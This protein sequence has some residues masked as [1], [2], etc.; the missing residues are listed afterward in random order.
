LVGILNSDGALN[1][2][3]FRASET[4]FQLLTQVS[5]RAGRGALE[6]EVYIQTTLPENQTIQFAAQQDYEAFY[7]TEI[8]VRKLFDYPPFN[9]LI[10]ITFSGENAKDTLQW[11]ENFRNYLLKLLPNTFQLQPVL[12]SGY[13]KIKDNYRFQLIIKGNQI[14]LFNKVLEQSKKDCPLPRAIKMIVD[15]NPSSTFF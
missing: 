11:S 13:S 2:P 8:A 12:P 5:G 15:V 7:K 1:I 10:K 4:V 9:Q 14:Y 3:D 6:G